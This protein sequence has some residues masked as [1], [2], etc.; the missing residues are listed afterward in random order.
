MILILS[1]KFWFFFLVFDLFCPFILFIL[2][3]IS[4]VFQ[5]C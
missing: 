5:W 3:N 1:V 2:P 4:A